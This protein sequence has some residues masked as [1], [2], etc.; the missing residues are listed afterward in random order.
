VLPAVLLYMVASGILSLP[1]SKWRARR[2]AVRG[3]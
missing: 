2:G 3:G 1:Y